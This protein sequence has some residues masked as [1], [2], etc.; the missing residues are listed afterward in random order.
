LKERHDPE[1]YTADREIARH[2]AQFRLHCP[3]K[4]RDALGEEHEGER[5]E[6][7]SRRDDGRRCRR[8]GAEL[9]RKIDSGGTHA[10]SLSAPEIFGL[11]IR[12]AEAKATTETQG[13]LRFLCDLCASVVTGFLI[14]THCYML[15]SKCYVH[16]Y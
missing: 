10:G 8:E 9:L 7:D 4:R 2:P 5:Q 14:L 11:P 13:A 6:D 12:I 15:S 3:A 1:G 16:R